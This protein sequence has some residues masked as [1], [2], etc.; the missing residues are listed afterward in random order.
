MEVNECTELPKGSRE[1]TDEVSEAL[2][3]LLWWFAVLGAMRSESVPA[4]RRAKVEVMAMIE[5]CVADEVGGRF[6]GCDMG[7]AS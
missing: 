2:P 3:R 5:M 1:A 4:A 7:S 6:C